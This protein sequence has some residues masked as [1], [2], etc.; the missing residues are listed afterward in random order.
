MN[1]KHISQ[2]FSSWLPHK[3]NVL[4]TLLAL[5]AMLWAQT[6]GVISGFVPAATRSTTEISPLSY[7]GYL[8][9]DDS[10]P[11][12]GT[13][14]M[15]F[16]LYDA[17][18]GG[19]LLWGELWVDNN[20]VAVT[21]GLF[22]VGLGQFNTELTTVL[23]NN[24]NLYLGISV[25]TGGEPSVTPE[26]ELTPRSQL[27]STGRAATALTVPNGSITREKL[28]SDVIQTH[29]Q[30]GRVHD[31]FHTEG[32]TL[33]NGSGGRTYSIHVDF[34]TPFEN[35]PVV[36]TSLA[37]MDID[38]TTGIRLSTYTENITNSG[39]DVVLYTW[40]NTRVYGATVMWI[41]HSSDE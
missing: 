21:D 4:F 30:T 18:T 17:P 1:D 27:G 19:N 2:R 3:G 23:Q 35:P 40:D 9:D 25:G 38:N 29:I 8:A 31:D 33:L 22:N 37:H 12:T 11:L 16:R 13:Y 36:H 26:N 34:E 14:D 32:W 5:G 7:Q 10:I 6:A 28:S 41:A 24:P 15:A 39:F 20:A